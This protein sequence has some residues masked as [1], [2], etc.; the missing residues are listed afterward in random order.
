MP[1]EVSS[2]GAGGVSAEAAAAAVHRAAALLLRRHLRE[3]FVLTLLNIGATAFT[4]G[5]SGG[6]EQ[7]NNGAPM[8]GTMQGAM[9]PPPGDAARAA[10]AA[11][12]ARRSYARGAGA[13]VS[14]RAERALR[15]GPGLFPEPS[16]GA[17]AD[18]AA[19]LAA[20]R[21]LGDD[22]GGGA[23]SGDDDAAGGS[24][25]G[26]SDDDDAIELALLTGG[27][28]AQQQHAPT[29][30]P[31]PPPQPPYRAAAAALAPSPPPPLHPQQGLLR[32]FGSPAAALPARGD[33]AEGAA[34]A[35]RCAECGR[36]LRDAAAAA[37][38]A[39]WHMARALQRAERAKPPP[40]QGRGNKHKGGPL[41]AFVRRGAAP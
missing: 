22:D 3:P 33:A 41:D 34:P 37:E 15:E 11:V 14:K 39:D 25:G 9:P 16:L 29:A 28:R 1:E 4:A 35:E 10:A 30:S 36:A 19:E 7:G 27:G 24:D 31:Q 12:E 2:R 18:V 21:W 8:M 40:P 23:C 6:G 5:G 26:W 13:L 38:H 17:A 20:E 32:F